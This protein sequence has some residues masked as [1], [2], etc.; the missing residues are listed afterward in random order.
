MAFFT[1]PTKTFKIFIETQKTPKSQNNLAK[2]E[3]SW[4][5]HSPWPQTILQSYRNQNSM[6][7]SQK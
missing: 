1:K 3:L 7:L 4:R 5:D 2:E 6:V